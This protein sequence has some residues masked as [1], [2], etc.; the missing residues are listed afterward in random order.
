MTPPPF[1][2]VGSRSS[3]AARALLPLLTHQ[4]HGTPS[5]I[6][7][8]PHDNPSPLRP[9][10]WFPLKPNRACPFTFEPA[11]VPL[12][13][14]PV[15][16]DS[17][18]VDTGGGGSRGCW[19]GDTGGG[20]WG[21]VVGTGGCCWGEYGGG[22]GGLAGGAGRAGGATG[23]RRPPCYAVCRDGRWLLSG[24]H[25]DCTVR[26]TLLTRSEIVVAGRQHC[27]VVTCVDVGSDGVTFAT[28]VEE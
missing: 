6:P 14:L 25:D 16:G 18:S 11:A 22:E 24:G 19:S 8:Q 23:W 10:S 12:A 2:T 5:P 3:P 1:L 26:C 17:G 20:D 13:T 27:G 9:R 4:L 7:H 15:T 28:G 21:G